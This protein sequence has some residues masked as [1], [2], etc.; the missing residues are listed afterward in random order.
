[1][2]AID[3]WD[4]NLGAVFERFCSARNGTGLDADL[5]VRLRQVGFVVLMLVY[6]FWFVCRC[7]VCTVSPSLLA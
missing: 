5:F 4:V 1:M 2:H 3:Y 7:G 6:M